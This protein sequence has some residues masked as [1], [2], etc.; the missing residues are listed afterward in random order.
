[1]K[2]IDA[3]SVWIIQSFVMMFK[4][5]WSSKFWNDGLKYMMGEKPES[6]LFWR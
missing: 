4:K 6:M 1:M 5:L 2:E 3:K